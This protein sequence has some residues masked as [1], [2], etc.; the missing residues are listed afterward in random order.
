MT[1][2]ISAFIK[3]ACFGVEDSVK[4]AVILLIRRGAKDSPR[5][6]PHSVEVFIV[7]A[8]ETGDDPPSPAASATVP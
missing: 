5:S 7:P 6:N 3:Q 1:E 4:I 2:R 8:Y